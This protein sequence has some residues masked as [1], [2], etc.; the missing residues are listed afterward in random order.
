MERGGGKGGRSRETQ[1]LTGNERSEEAGAAEVQGAK[2]TGGREAGA[3]RLRE[4]SR[5]RAERMRSG[6]RG[7]SER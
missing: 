6:D 7:V 2:P 3:S 4:D 5:A 1:I